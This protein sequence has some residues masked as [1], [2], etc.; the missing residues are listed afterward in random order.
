MLTG[1]RV[2]SQTLAGLGIQLDEADVAEVGAV[3]QPERTVGRIAK[4]ARIDGVAVLD[5]VGPDHRPRRPPTCSPAN[6]G[7]ASCRPAARSRPWAA[8]RAPNSRRN[9]C[10]PNGS[11]PAPRCCC[12]RAR[13]RPRR[14]VRRG[15]PA[16]TCRRAATSSRH[17]TPRWADRCPCRSCRTSRRA[18]RRWMGRACADLHPGQT[19]AGRAP[20]WLSR[21]GGVS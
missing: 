4:H 10:R 13:S 6:P 21:E 5:A 9:T 17:R 7:R 20:G 1:F 18:A 3:G 12:R 2:R 8:C 15:V 16:S 19:L 11:R 14:D